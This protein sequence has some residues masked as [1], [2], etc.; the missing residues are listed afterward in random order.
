MN[1]VR[2]LNGKLQSPFSEYKSITSQKHL[3]FLY[4]NLLLVKRGKQECNCARELIV[5]SV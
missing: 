4:L 2:H 1:Y 3:T 5:Y